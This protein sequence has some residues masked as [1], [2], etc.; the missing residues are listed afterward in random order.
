MDQKGYGDIRGLQGCRE[1][2][3]G[4]RV[5]RGCQ[6]VLGAGRTLGTQG[7]EGV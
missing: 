1:S 4:F 5:C 2:V 7:P 6:G 3:W